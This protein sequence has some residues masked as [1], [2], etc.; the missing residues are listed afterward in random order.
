MFAA[1]IYALDDGPGPIRAWR[2]FLA[3]HGD[4]VGTLCGFSTAGGEDFPAEYRGKRG[5]T[6]GC[7]YNCDAAAG[8]TLLQPLRQL[9]PMVADF[10]C[11]KTEGRRVGHGVGNTCT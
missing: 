7:G 10:S 11:R 2:E 6:L 9:G 8:G 1:P 5:Y 4:R 3:K